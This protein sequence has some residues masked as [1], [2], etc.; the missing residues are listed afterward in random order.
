MFNPLSLFN[1][2]KMVALQD[3]VIQ[4]VKLS[5]YFFNSRL[6]AEKV[7]KIALLIE[8]EQQQRGPRPPLPAILTI[9]PPT[10][11]PHAGLHGGIAV[12]LDLS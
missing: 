3:Q 2:F 11:P 12:K 4:V 7:S 8:E 1:P 5:P 9:S 10:A 6:T